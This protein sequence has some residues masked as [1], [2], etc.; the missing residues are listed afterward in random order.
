MSMSGSPVKMS[1]A[2]RAAKSRPR[3]DDPAWSSTGRPW[4]ERGTV[5]GPRTWNHSPVVVELVDLVGIGEHAV[6]PVE[7][8]GVVLPGVPQ[9]GGGLEELV[10]P[11]V[12]LVV[13][14]VLGRTRSSGPR[15][16]SPT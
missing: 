6:G 11:V 13:A 8:Q 15:C 7:H 5:S 3:P 1:S 16:R 4:G 2:Q 10:G 14:E 9:P 12:A